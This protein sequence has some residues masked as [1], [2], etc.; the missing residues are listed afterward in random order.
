MIFS[1]ID[2]YRKHIYLVIIDQI[3]VQGHMLNLLPVQFSISG[4]IQHRF[5]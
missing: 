1:E 2:I 3:P 5:A 4:Y